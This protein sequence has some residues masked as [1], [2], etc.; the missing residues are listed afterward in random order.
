[1]DLFKKH[2]MPKP[3][4]RLNPEI[5]IDTC[6]TDTNDLTK[7]VKKIKLSRDSGQTSTPMDCSYKRSEIELKRSTSDREQSG[8]KRQKIQWP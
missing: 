5:K 4:R 6:I 8:N 7:E 1:M 2:I 3:Q